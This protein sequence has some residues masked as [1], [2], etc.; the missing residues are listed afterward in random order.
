[1]YT[2]GFFDR[3]Y[4]IRSTH[5][6]LE[7]LAMRSPE[8]INDIFENMF[9]SFPPFVDNSNTLIS[10][11]HDNQEEQQQH[12][13]HQRDKL[14]FDTSQENLIPS[15]PDTEHETVQCTMSEPKT[16][17]AE[18]DN[19]NNENDSCGKKRK[20]QD[21]N[22]P[23]EHIVSDDSVIIINTP[24]TNPTTTT[25]TNINNNNNNNNDTVVTPTIQEQSINSTQ[26]ML[27]PLPSSSITWDTSIP[28]SEQIATRLYSTIIDMYDSNPSNRWIRDLLKIIDNL[29]LHIVEWKN[30]KSKLVSCVEWDKTIRRYIYMIAQSND[31]DN[32]AI[33]E[34]VHPRL[35]K[36]CINFLT[37]L[38][39]L[40]F[41]SYLHEEFHSSVC[42]L[43]S[44]EN[45]N[46]DMYDWMISCLNKIYSH[47]ME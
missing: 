17:C 24:T 16:E 45:I 15:L 32:S 19:N 8:E 26:R 10:L 35:H 33:I 43:K 30:N 1:M 11:Q 6:N 47:K 2:G 3:H 44:I 5:F 41:Q 22:Q 40:E 4:T 25:T 7:H 13:H 28:I 27:Q 46:V 37:L 9:E 38:N 42:Y 31:I 14:T 39:P 21:D 12:H 36:F 23:E 29:V 18:T 20:R 34:N